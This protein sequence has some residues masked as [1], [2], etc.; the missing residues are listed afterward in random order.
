M[1]ALEHLEIIVVP[2][3]Q[4]FSTVG[5]HRLEST[6]RQ[7]SVEHGAR[8]IKKWAGRGHIYSL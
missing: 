1:H 3:G 7:T 4:V 2:A 5:Q 8:D 6:A